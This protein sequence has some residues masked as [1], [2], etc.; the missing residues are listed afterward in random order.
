[1]EL[2]NKLRLS[3]QEAIRE[4]PVPI[5]TGERDKM[6]LE[7]AKQVGATAVLATPISTLDLCQHIKNAVGFTFRNYIFCFWPP[8]SF[9]RTAPLSGQE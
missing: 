9:S 4:I 3:K 2:C 7:V 1:M 6:P 5:L 8:Y